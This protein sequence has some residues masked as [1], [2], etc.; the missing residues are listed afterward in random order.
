MLG[1]I[2]C[3]K[4]NVELPPLATANASSHWHWTLP[5]SLSRGWVPGRLKDASDEQWSKLRPFA[6]PL[7]LGMAAHCAVGQAVSSI[8]SEGRRERAVLVWQAAAGISFCLFLHG[9]RAIWAVAVC[10]LNYCMCVLLG[11][12]VLWR[13]LH[14]LP[15][16]AWSINVG[17]LL[18][19]NL[20]DGFAYV[21]FASWAGAAGARDSDTPCYCSSSNTLPPHT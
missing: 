16:A 19:C 15:C 11:R 4:F 2:S 9:P 1:I 5:H 14:A 17:L 18:L 20:Y 3:N 13:Q 21:P 8:V 12:R 10:A 7:L 6:L